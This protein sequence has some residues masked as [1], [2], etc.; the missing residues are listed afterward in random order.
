MVPSRRSSQSPS[1]PQAAMATA[2]VSPNEL[3]FPTFSQPARLSSMTGYFTLPSLDRLPPVPLRLSPVTAPKAATLFSREGMRSMT[4][5]LPSQELEALIREGVIAADRP[6]A[7]GQIQPASMDLRL[8]PR[9]WRVS[10]SFLPGAKASVRK[11][12]DELK[13]YDLD[14]STPKV[15]EKGQVYIVQLMESVKLPPNF[16]GRANPK[17][18]TGRLDIFTRLITDHCSEYEFVEDRYAGPLYIEIVPVQ[19]SVIVQAGTSLNQLRII[20]GTPTSPDVDESDTRIEDLDRRE[21]LVYDENSDP[22]KAKVWDGLMLS[23]DLAGRNPGDLVGFKAKKNATPIDLSLKAH[24]EAAEFWEPIYGGPGKPLVLHPDDF[25]ILASK[26]RVRVPLEYAGR[27]IEIDP[28]YGEFRVHYAGFFDPGFGYGNNDV[29]G[30]R[31]VLEVR[32]HEVPFQM[33]D[34]QVVGRLKYEKLVAPPA[35]VYGLGIGS[36]YQSQGVALSKQFKA[37]K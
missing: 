15:L 22:H 25:Y 32:S 11:K 5:V 2:A 18:T 17:S 29:L 33:E 23:I 20:H 35:K 21:K 26:E 27:L 3:T 6:I 10:A 30:T 16:Y 36:S 4:G 8:G 7:D 12:I 14:L 28:S 1:A 34:G 24:Y 13:V 37:F 9:A 31:A 19:F